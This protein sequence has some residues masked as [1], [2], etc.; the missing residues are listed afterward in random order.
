VRAHDENEKRRDERG[1]CE[2][3]VGEKEGEKA[4]QQESN[5]KK[6]SC[7]PYSHPISDIK[8]CEGSL[9]SNVLHRAEVTSYLQFH[10]EPHDLYFSQL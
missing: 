7:A 5:A 6:T 9:S 3:A 1:C 8:Q 2:N 4:E 10:S